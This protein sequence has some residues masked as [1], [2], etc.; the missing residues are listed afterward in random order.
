MKCPK[1]GKTIDNDSNFCEYCGMQVSDRGTS[2]DSITLWIKRKS[3]YVGCAVPYRIIINDKGIAKLNNGADCCIKL[4]RKSFNLKIDLE[5]NAIHKVKTEININPND[6]KG[7]NIKCVVSTHGKTLG[8][9][10]LGLFAPI[11]ELKCDVFEDEPKTSVI[12]DITTNKNEQPMNY[13]FRN[14]K[15][16]NNIVPYS[17]LALKENHLFFSYLYNNFQDCKIE[18]KLTAR[19]V[20]PNAPD[21][22][23]PIN[24]MITK[25][26]KRTVVLLVNGSL[27]KRYSVLETMELCK[28]NGITPLRFVI[29][30]EAWSNEEQYVV[31][32]IRK[33]L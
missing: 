23:M 27:C 10:S 25:G 2:Y 18:S 11:C 12:T 26:N 4:P 9:L 7:N 28:E 30:N 14:I 3:D 13:N 16:V 22:A 33:T 20:F 29:D 19:Q 1:C 8:L 15:D 21:Y 24:F 5:G 17:T 32:R 6:F 31:N